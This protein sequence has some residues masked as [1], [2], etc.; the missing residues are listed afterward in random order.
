MLMLLLTHVVI[1]LASVVL[2]GLAYIQPSQ[3]KLH[4]SYALVGLTLAS[5]TALVITTHSALLSSCMTGLFYL[6]IVLSGI[7]AARRK[8]ASEELL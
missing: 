7:V 8:L 3:A 1:A 4:S 6:G 2:T 5:G